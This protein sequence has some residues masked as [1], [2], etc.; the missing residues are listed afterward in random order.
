[1][2]T[3]LEWTTS[4]NFASL[5]LSW[6]F[7]FSCSKEASEPLVDIESDTP[8]GETRCDFARKAMRKLYVGNSL[9]TPADMHKHG[10]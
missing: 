6:H 10:E 8:A 4:P 2:T 5:E 9:F 1:M 3:I 7:Q